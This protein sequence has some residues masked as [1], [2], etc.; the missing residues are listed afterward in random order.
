MPSSP[1]EAVEQGNY[2]WLQG[3]EGVWSHR[4]APEN[5]L[6]A[7]PG[8]PL[9]PRPPWSAT[10]SDPQ[11]SSLMNYT[12]IFCRVC[13]LCQKTLNSSTANMFLFTRMLPL[14]L[15]AEPR[16]GRCIL[17]NAGNCCHRAQRQWRR[18]VVMAVVVRIGQPNQY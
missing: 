14:T 8:G 17:W 16:N 1:R 15:L 3:R 10:L 13:R 9:S 12:S 5:S 2:S 11:L 18:S 6:S 7:G 4:S